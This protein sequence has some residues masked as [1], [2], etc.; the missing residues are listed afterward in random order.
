MIEVFLNRIG[1]A[2]PP[3]EVHATFRAFAAR[4]LPERQ[5]AVFGRMA[6]R[7][8]IDRRWSVLAPA[9]S[10]ADPGDG[11][12]D[13][14]DAAGL[15]TA[16]A[17]PS[18]GARM[19]RYAAEAPGLA[20]AALADL[21]PVAGITHLVVASCTGFVAP[22]LDHAIA[23]RLGLDEG[24]AR[25]CV[26][27]MG[28]QAAIV[29][30][31]LAR[32][33]VRAD[34]AARVLV[35]NVELCTLHLQERADLDQLLCFLLFADGASAALV[36]AEPGGLRLDAFRA[37]LMPEAAAQITW[38]IGDAGFDMVLSGQVPATLARALPGRAGAILG[39]AAPA[40]FDLWAVHPGG[41]SV[42]DAVEAA[43]GLP[44]AALA[45]SRAVLR[46]HGNMSSPT[47]MFVLRALMDRA[48]PGQRGVAMAFGPGLSAET[49]RFA[50]AA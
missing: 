8:G 11:G 7:A 16:G 29:A 2:V 46:D 38:A 41:R 15:Y 42:L 4:R 26:G 22:G 28:C 17:F 34:P 5:R 47:V 40:A 14:V 27:F 12:P 31:R 30:L 45:A 1:T 20:L 43:F 6:A 23:A 19:A 13:R 3:H 18:T 10:P 44:G 32:D 21:G 25:T 33:A 9:A 49:L 35:V 24:V 39:G 36:S 37:A 48:A 50:V